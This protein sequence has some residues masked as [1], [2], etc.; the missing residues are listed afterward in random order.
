MRKLFFLLFG[1]ILLIGIVQGYVYQENANTTTVVGTWNAPTQA[2]NGNWGDRGY[3]SSGTG[4]IYF[5]YTK[6]ERAV[7]NTIWQVKDTNETE[8]Y[9]LT[10]PDSCFTYDTSTLELRVRANNAPPTDTIWSCYD[11]TGWNTLRNTSVDRLIFEDGIFWNASNN[12]ISVVLDTPSNKTSTSATT[13]NF[14]ANYSY[15][16]ITIDN[17]TYY[18]WNSDNSLFNKT[19]RS[20]IPNSNKTNLSVSGFTQENYI[21]NVYA[22][23]QNATGGTLCSWSSNGNFTFSIIKFTQN[24]ILFNSSSYETKRENFRLNITTSDIVLSSTFTYAGTTYPSTTSCP[25]ATNCLM[26]A[27]IDLPVS[28]A[29]INNTFYWT[30]NF[31]NLSQNTESYGQNVTKL[32]FGLCNATWTVP[33][34]NYTFKDE[35]TGNPLNATIQTSTFIY[36]LGGGTTNRTLTFVNITDNLNYAFCLLA[37][38]NI[39]LNVSRYVQYKGTNYPQRTSSFS[40]YLTNTTTN[41]ILYLV[42][43]S[44]GLYVTFQV[45]GSGGTPL[46]GVSVSGTRTI[47]TST[48]T[49]VYGTTGDDGGVTF[50]LSPD[51]EHTFTFVKTGYD[52]YVTSLYP[53]QSLYTISL[54]SGTTTTTASDYKKEIYILIQPS[55]DFIDKG[56]VYSFNYTINSSYWTL[57]EFGFTLKY[58]NG[59]VLGTSSSTGNW[60]VV[61]RNANSSLSAKI[62]MDWYYVINGTYIN[63]TRYWLTQR[64]SDFSITH[65]FE[66]VSLYIGANLLGINGEDND[67]NFGKAIISVLILVLVAGT[68][69][70]RYGLNSEPAIMG[71]VF[72]IVLL[73][74]TVG[75]IPNPDFMTG[76]SLGTVISFL[77]LILTI[78]FIFKEE[79]R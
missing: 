21:W 69:T 40:S 72:G 2:Y 32:H 18:I 78:A 36:W 49:I 9:N 4:T 10:I 29:E 24:D 66:D 79:Q 75:F 50:W 73:L 55:K 54:G 46:T 27:S 77:I 53:T 37:P 65:F 15:S 48:E 59:T 22:C 70:Y 26:N 17:G 71:I 31:I 30:L 39:G 35:I 12:A 57:S 67:S 20:V 64:S 38:T 52:T 13:F 74:D 28:S 42:G 68:L 41:T 58:S 3:P 56:K 33:Y 44:D 43:S 25:I 47:G 76:V 19:A 14:T 34:I 8:I 11:N 51:F 61:N 5:N 62:I 45:I 63:G 1:M 6:V 7:A 60:G 16:E 23:G